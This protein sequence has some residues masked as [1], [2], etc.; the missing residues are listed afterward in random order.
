MITRPAT[1]VATPRKAG[2]SRYVKI[3]EL[4]ADLDITRSTFYDWRAKQKAP[5]CF[6]IP[7]GELRI[8]RTEYEAWL[9][10]LEEEVA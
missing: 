4:L 3:P 1:R 7:N 6:K 9:A 5:R 10:T 2:S 8:L